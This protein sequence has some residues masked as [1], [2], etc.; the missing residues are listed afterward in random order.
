MTNVNCSNCG[1]A[2]TL[3]NR[4]DGIIKILSNDKTLCVNYNYFLCIDC[5]KS[6]Y[7]NTPILKN[8]IS[9]RLDCDRQND[10]NKSN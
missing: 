10:G 6:K 4:D 1:R 7:R 9:L 2:F 3:S 8:R 5:M